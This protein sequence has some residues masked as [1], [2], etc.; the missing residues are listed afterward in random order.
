[1]RVFRS[2]KDGGVRRSSHTR[3][4]EPRGLVACAL[5]TLHERAPGFRLH[6][7]AV[8]LP[9]LREVGVADGVFV[10][11]TPLLGE[12]VV[13]FLAKCKWMG[14][15]SGSSTILARIRCCGRLYK[16]SE[17]STYNGT[18]WKHA[19]K[20]ML[21]S[22]TT[23]CFGRVIMIVSGVCHMN[24]C[25]GNNDLLICSRFYKLGR[26]TSLDTGRNVTRSPT[27]GQSF[28]STQ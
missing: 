21:V 26:E 9:Y 22:N 23:C 20:G 24:V 7:G 11:Q 25:R 4:P 18:P 27:Q 17:S 6:V 10:V 5:V 28:V 2:S 19:G 12:D 14:R 16:D 13:K 1:M 3:R 8:L 15:G